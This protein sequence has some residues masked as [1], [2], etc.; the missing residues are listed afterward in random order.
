[1]SCP[2]KSRPK[3]EDL[4]NIHLLESILPIDDP[5]MILC[6]LRHL[7][8]FCSQK[9]LGSLLYVS[10]K[11][12]YRKI[13]FKD[14]LKISLRYFIHSKRNSS[15]EKKCQISST[16]R[17]PLTME[18]FPWKTSWEFFLST[19][20]LILIFYPENTFWNFF[21]HIGRFFIHRTPLRSLWFINNLLNISYQ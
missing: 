14:F 18:E 4:L 12:F 10:Q 21:I 3:V 2:F 20:Y 1:M 5:L 11:V 17:R 7:P 19:K 6:Y 15:K 8:I 9:V 16:L 13:S